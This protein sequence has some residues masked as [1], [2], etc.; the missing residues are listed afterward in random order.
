MALART[1]AAGLAW[2]VGEAM[3]GTTSAVS[4]GPEPCPQVCETPSNEAGNEWTSVTVPVNA[5]SF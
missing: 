5:L 3:T 2:N 1:D 4:L